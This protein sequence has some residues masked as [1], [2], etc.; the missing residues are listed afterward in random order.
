LH[1][2]TVEPATVSR[3][4]EPARVAGVKEE[5]LGLPGLGLAGGIV[6]ERQMYDIQL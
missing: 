5:S 4:F 2:N 3:R 6:E 1:Y